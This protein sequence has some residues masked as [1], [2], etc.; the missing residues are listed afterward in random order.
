MTWRDGVHLVGTVLWCDARRARD[1]CFV[2]SAE[3]IGRAG[4]GQLIATRETLAQLG[5]APEHLPI[6]YRRPF[7]LGTVR[8]ELLPSGHAIGA[9]TLI[10]EH[11]GKRIA[12]SGAIA[13]HGA[14][15]SQ[16]A[17]PPRCDVLV[18]DAPYGKPEHRFGKAEAHAAA[19]L[20]WTRETTARGDAAIVLVTSPQKG[21]DVVHALSRNAALPIA[22][23]P[24]IATAAKRLGLLVP[25]AVAG[26]R[27][28]RAAA[29]RVLVWLTRDVASAALTPTAKHVIARRAL[30]SGLAVEPAAMREL[31]AE[32]AIAWSN[33]ADR[34][35]LLDYIAQTGAKEIYLTGRC[36]DIVASAVGGHARVL[37]PPT[38]MSLWK[39]VST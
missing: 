3:R 32:L 13:T 31:G 34:A 12:F 24:A 38:Q 4:H 11:A 21:L 25:A 19:L 28:G 27:G 5:A 26:V 33:S 23:H 36:A 29:G 16:P 6:P 8:L 17:T 18:V 2:S 20:H 30:V 37:A 35:T 15:L 9:A 39:A 14:G 7:T 22:A 1:V 10:T